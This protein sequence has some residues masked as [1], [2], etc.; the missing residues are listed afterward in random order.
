MINILEDYIWKS[1]PDEMFHTNQ[2]LRKKAD[3]NGKILPY[4]GN[5]VVFLLD[6]D[7]KD[8]LEELQKELYAAVP[9]MFSEKL[10]R[11]TFHMVLLPCARDGANFINIRVIPSET[12]NP[13]PCGAGWSLFFK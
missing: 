6:D 13:A 1:I 9:H 3:E 7:T 5:T 10:E 4:K 2:N 8:F 12:K 11:D